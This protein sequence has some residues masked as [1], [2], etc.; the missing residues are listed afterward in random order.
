[1]TAGYNINLDNKSTLR[2]SGG[3]FNVF[4]SE[5][6]TEGNPRAG[7]AQTNSGDFFVGRPILPRSYYL[8]VTFTF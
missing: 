2:L 7:D 8:R 1:L 4:N 5:G 3:V 6:I